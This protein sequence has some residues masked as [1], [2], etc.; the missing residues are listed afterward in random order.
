MKQ[1]DDGS[2]TNLA[3]RGVL[4]IVRWK[5]THVKNLFFKFRWKCCIL[6]QFVAVFRVCWPNFSFST[7]R[8]HVHRDK[9]E[10]ALGRRNSPPYIKV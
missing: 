10:A 3:S 5:S 2:G 1:A 9:R 6:M 4:S 7:T 8:F